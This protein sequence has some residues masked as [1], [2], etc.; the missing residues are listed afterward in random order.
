MPQA[1]QRSDRHVEAAARAARDFH[2]L[3]EDV[4]E[5]WIDA[6]ESGAAGANQLRELGLGIE[7]AHHVV[8]PDDF[9]EG[10]INRGFR[11]R[12]RRM[13]GRDVEHRP[14]RVPLGVNED[15]AVRRP[16]AG[17]GDQGNRGSL[18]EAHT[19]RPDRWPDTR[20]RPTRSAWSSPIR[21]G[22]G[23]RA[24]SRWRSRMP[25]WTRRSF[26]RR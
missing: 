8:E 5:R 16:E 4:V 10:H 3:A 25:G 21:P 2:R 12:T 23:A 9:G 1:Y 17:A 14:H 18:N 6:D 15:H 11:L 24:P 22:S 7:G 19:R 13:I 26:A 20:L